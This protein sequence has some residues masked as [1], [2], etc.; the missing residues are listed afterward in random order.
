MR[1]TA[2]LVSSLAGADALLSCSSISM[3]NSI[4]SMRS[5]R[6]Q[7]LTED[8][9]TDEQMAAD[10]TAAALA[11]T[12]AAEEAARLRAKPKFDIRELAGV[13]APLGFWDPASFSEGKSEGTLRF[14]REVEIKH[15]RVAMLAAVGFPVAEHFHPL[16]GGQ[17]D[18]P[19][20]VAFQQ[21][22]LQTF[23]PA[24]ILAIST[25]EVVSVFTF[26]RPYDL[27][28]TAAGGVWS[29]RSDHAP[30]DMRFDPLNLKPK[31]SAG[32]KDMETKELNHG[33][34]AMIG[35]AGMVVQEVVSGEKLW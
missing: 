7:M 8:I 26:E 1:R 2:V 31:D 17:I 11:V 16:W 21:T 29:I 6:T 25:Y 9:D 13:S 34:L 19:S 10:A 28:Y 12:E 27:Y 33:R 15:S 5:G 22:P 32:L 30:G 20:Y 4:I 18:V 35:I 3:R 24:V 14:Y 23:W